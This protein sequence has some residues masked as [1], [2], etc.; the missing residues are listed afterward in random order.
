[1][2]LIETLRQHLSSP[3]SEIHRCDHTT[4]PAAPS[5][6]PC[7]PVCSAGLASAR[8]LLVWSRRRHALTPRAAFRSGFLALELASRAAPPWL[9]T[10]PIP[11]LGLAAD[12]PLL[13]HGLR[14]LAPHL[15]LVLSDA[16]T[17]ERLQKAGVNHA[18]PALLFGV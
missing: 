14:D 5:C 4:L 6:P 1:M 9:L 17:T 12:G 10:A 16:P 13:W 15:D 2:P 18:R 3:A 8:L 7:W 11:V